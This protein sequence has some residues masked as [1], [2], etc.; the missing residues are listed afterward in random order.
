MASSFGHRNDHKG[1]LELDFHIVVGCPA[2]GDWK[3]K[4]S[5]RA[6]AGPPA[7]KR[8]ERSINLKLN[9]PLALFETPTIVAKINIADVGTQVEIDAEAVSEAVRGAIGMDVDLQ[10]IDQHGEVV[11]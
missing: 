10:V 2:K 7:L 6:V 4:P 11:G 9:L 5:V 3:G 8:N 1:L